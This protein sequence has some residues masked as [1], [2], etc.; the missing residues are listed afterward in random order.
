MIIKRLRPPRL[1]NLTPANQTLLTGTH[2][3]SSP[4]QSLT[5]QA[6]WCMQMPEVIQIFRRNPSAGDVCLLIKTP[7]PRCRGR[8]ATLHWPYLQVAELLIPYVYQNQPNPGTIF[9]SVQNFGTSY[10]FGR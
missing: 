5:L 8:T 9:A 1:Q 7:S 2:S 3:C 6:I 10:G 4:H